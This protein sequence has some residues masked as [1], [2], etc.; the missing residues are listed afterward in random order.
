MVRDARRRAPHHEG[1][2]IP[3][4]F[5]QAAIL[6]LPPTP[7]PRLAVPS[8]VWTAAFSASA[9]CLMMEVWICCCV[10]AAALPA[11]SKPRPS[12]PYAAFLKREGTVPRHQLTNSGDGDV[13][14]NALSDFILRNPEEARKRRLEG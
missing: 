12:C 2:T 7:G 3:T 10:P 13:A 6:R 8:S 1:L 11:C 4:G 9:F 14:A 5:A